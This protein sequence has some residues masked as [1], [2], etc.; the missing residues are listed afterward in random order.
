MRRILLFL[1]PILIHNQQRRATVEQ[2]AELLTENGREVRLQ[3]TLSAHSAGQQAR[4]AVAEGFD[5]FL[6]CGGDGTIFQVLQGLAGADVSL[7][8][9]PFGTG[10]VIA[11]NLGMPRDPLAAARMLLT[12][13]PREVSLGQVALNPLGHRRLRS[14]YFL[15][16]AGMGVHAA[17]MNLA[18]TGMGK[19]RGGRLA[20]YLGGA[21]LLM[22]HP[23][24]PFHLDLTLADGSTA[25]ET[26][27]EAIA[28][29]MAEINRWRPGGDPFGAELQVAWVPPAGRVGLAHASFHAL[30]TGKKNGRGWLGL[31]FA[32]YVRVRKMVCRPLEG[33]DS[34]A[35][36]LVEADGEVLGASYASVGISGDRLKL[37]WPERRR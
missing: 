29:H 15:I 10:N 22:R 13:T 11:Q 36:L 28:V 18:P 25:S 33:G 9:L 34:E 19:R 14:W 1:N 12:A 20:Y 4:E 7:G 24:Q 17:L 16:A 30:M 26:A 3:E 37:L 2:I 5:T 23:V 27:C 31:P 21:K 35:S 8:V 6:V 32:Q